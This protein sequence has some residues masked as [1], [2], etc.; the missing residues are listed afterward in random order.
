MRGKRNSHRIPN[1]GLV[2]LYPL[3]FPR[4]SPIF[5]RNNML[6]P[7]SV[8]L[9]KSN[10][11]SGAG[12]QSGKKPNSILAVCLKLSTKW[13]LRSYKFFLSENLGLWEFF[14]GLL[15]GFQ[16]W[17]FS[18]WEHPVLWTQHAC[19]GALGPSRDLG[20]CA[21]WTGTVLGQL[22]PATPQLPI[23]GSLLKPWDGKV[24]DSLIFRSGYGPSLLGNSTLWD[25]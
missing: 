11:W 8:P 16:K 25:S 3:A 17:G 12:H 14:M 2:C 18:C 15:L 13:P 24:N 21:L 19:P 22:V 5:W 23:A 4:S 10:D 6:T 1:L 9:C 20:V 7:L